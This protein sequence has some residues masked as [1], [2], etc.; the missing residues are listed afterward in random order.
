MVDALI[1]I[2]LVPMVYAALAV[3]FVGTGVRIL[4]IYRSPANP[5]TLR[6][7]PEKQPK[8]LWVL[9][10]TFLL[11]TVRRRNPLMR[12]RPSMPARYHSSPAVG[13]NAFFGEAFFEGY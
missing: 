2:V 6:I 4:G 11:P 1:Y 13:S 9:H 12:I 3:F 10:D 8:W 5:A 7:Y